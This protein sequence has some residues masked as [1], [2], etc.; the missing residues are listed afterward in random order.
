VLFAKFRLTT[1]NAASAFRFCDPRDASML[2]RDCNKLD[3]VEKPDSYSYEGGVA[4]T[5][6]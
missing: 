6:F 3:A 4:S 1:R 2:F 5:H